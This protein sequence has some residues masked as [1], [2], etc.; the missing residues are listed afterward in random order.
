MKTNKTNETNE[1]LVIKLKPAIIPIK[2][3]SKK[4]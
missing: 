3:S 1:T 2:K 4:D